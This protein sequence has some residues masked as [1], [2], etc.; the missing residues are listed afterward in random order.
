M[1]RMLQNKPTKLFIKLTTDL[2][3]WRQPTQDEWTS[4]DLL[5]RRLWSA[6]AGTHRRNRCGD[7]RRRTI[8]H[9][10]RPRLPLQMFN[11][12]KFKHVSRR[13][14]IEILEKRHLLAGWQNPEIVCDVDYDNQV[15]QLDAL[16]VLGEISS[17]RHA[18]VSL[19]LEER[20][21]GSLLPYFDVN[22]DGWITALDALNVINAL[23]SV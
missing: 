22:E 14:A 19:Q 3:Y 11:T 10:R 18:G 17:R 13:L 15:T 4:D 6:A 2:A 21:P 16:V 5:P 8:A 12:F 9:N 20:P 7:P 1:Q 23:G